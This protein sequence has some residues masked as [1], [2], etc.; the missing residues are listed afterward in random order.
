MTA[1]KLMM[2]ACSLLAVGVVMPM[3]GYGSADAVPLWREKGLLP[4]LEWNGRAIDPVPAES[5][6]SFLPP[7]LEDEPVPDAQI[8]YR[9]GLPKI[10]INGVLVEPILNMSDVNCKFGLNQAAKMDAMGIVLNQIIFRKFD[11][12][13]K[14]G[15]YD[16]SRMNVYVRRMLKYAPSARILATIELELPKWTLA[17]PEAQVGYS[18]GPAESITTDDHKGRAIRPSSASPEYRVEVRHFFEEL[19]K[20]VAA[21]PWGKRIVAIRPSW[22]IYKEWHVYGMYHGPDC[23]P[24]MTAAFRRWKGGR[25]AKENVPTLEERNHDEAFFFNPADHAKL[26]EYYACLAS[27]TADFLIDAAKAAKRALPGRLVGAYYG[28]VLAIHPPEGATVL[29]D[30]VLASGAIDFMSNPAMYTAASRRAGGS[31]YLRTIPAT[32]HRYG[33]LMMIE[34]DMRHYHIR[35]FLTAHHK[36]TTADPREAEMTTRR[37]M[38]NAWFDGCGI[39]FLDCNAR[40]EERIFTHDAPEILQAI[41]DVRGFAPHLGPRPADSGNRTAVVVDERQ[42]FLRPSNHH[43]EYNAVY[44]NAIEGYYASGVPADLM[45][46][47]DFLAQPEGRYT[48]AVFLN[49]FSA[50]GKTAEL[51]H[52]R[53]DEKRFK[54]RW[55]LRSAVGTAADDVLSKVPTTGVKWRSL[56]T[57]LGSPAFAPPGHYVRRYGDRLMFHTGKAGRWTLTP[58]GYGGAHEVFSNKD[59]AGQSF[60]V[61]TDGPDTLLFLLKGKR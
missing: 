7:G 28:Y 61:E 43:D 39:Q 4:E 22:G 12:E 34:D 29:V 40:R 49:V 13:V 10:C 9:D 18:D 32:F 56:L 38:L 42:R 47:N 60:E 36:I 23:G 11:F 6:D 17:H 16:F 53:V 19:G 14:P 55:V 26:V 51:L 45:T 2:L 48:S 52:R 27:E 21:Q 8:V 5:S 41:Q 59:Y 44:V 3:A 25:Y 54:A 57:S 1:D 24:A 30:K 31:Y 37:N 58:T 46:L 15:L 33:K 20:Y 50:F 35:P